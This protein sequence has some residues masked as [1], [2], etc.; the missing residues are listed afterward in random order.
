MSRK[1]AMPIVVGASAPDGA[2]GLAA[3]TTGARPAG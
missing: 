1:P 3:A 2:T